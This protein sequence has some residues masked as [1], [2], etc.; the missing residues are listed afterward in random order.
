MLLGIFAQQG[1]PWYSTDWDYRIAIT[2]DAA[3][4]G[5][6][7]V[8]TFSPYVDLS[9]IPSGSDFWSH[10]AADGADIRVTK[11]DGVTELPREVVAIS[12]AG[13]TGELHF[14]AGAM[15]DSADETFYIYYGNSAA[16]EPAAAST[17]GKYAVWNDRLATWHLT[18]LLDSTAGQNTLSGTVSHVTGK[19]GDSL[20]ASNPAAGGD[21]VGL[22]STACFSAAMWV[23]RYILDA[24]DAFIAKWQYPGNGTFGIQGGISDGAYVAVYIATSV[25]DD[26]SGCRVD[27]TAGVFTED[28]WLRLVVVFDGALTGDSNRLK[29]YADGT[30]VTLTTGT[31]A[32]P[33]TLTAGDAAITLGDFPGLNRPLNGE[34][35]DVSIFDCAVDQ[36]W[37]TTDFNN[38]NDP[39]TFWKTVGSEELR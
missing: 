24:N 10:V 22:H 14:A 4:V 38:Q 23:K 15:S 39:A 29:M 5:T 28:E 37:I 7:G 6:G 12:T 27:S 1:S 34:L 18:G 33:E 19:V 11:S 21:I 31:G 36:A 13:H 17:Y 9:L 3:K 30:P 16:T 2:C 8:S 25:G 32:V 35:D 26:G 20:F